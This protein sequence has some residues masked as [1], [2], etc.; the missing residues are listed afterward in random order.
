MVLL[1]LLFLQQVGALY[2][3]PYSGPIDGMACVDSSPSTVTFPSFTFSAP[4]ASEPGSIGIRQIAFQRVGY[5]FYD[6]QGI[7]LNG[8][9]PGAVQNCCTAT[10]CEAAVQYQPWQEGECGL[11]WCGTENHWEY[12]DFTG[13]SPLIVPQNTNLTLALVNPMAIVDNF[14]S[15]ILAMSYDVIPASI[16]PSPTLSMTPSESLTPTSTSSMSPSESIT[17]TSTS[18]I[19]PSESL[20]PTSTSS[21]GY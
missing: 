2:F 18:S 14:G 4:T 19:T 17:P 15:P 6:N 5:G 9:S 3:Q 13:T 16:T 21:I 20:T 10:N 12:I 11:S 7:T 1:L 8:V